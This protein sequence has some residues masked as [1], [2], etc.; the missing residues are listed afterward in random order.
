MRATILIGG[1]I[2]SFDPMRVETADLVI[3][4]DVIGDLETKIPTTSTVDC[5]GCVIMPGF[6]V[7]HTHLYS[8]LAPGMPGPQSP[9]STFREILERIWWRLDEALDEESLEISAEIASAAALRAG[10]TTVVDHHESPRFIDGALDVIAKAIGEIGIRGV[11]AYGATDRHGA[12]G[13][14]RGLAESERF[15]RKMKDD[16][17]VRGM[18]G[19]HAPFTC[20]DRTL[21]ACRD[22]IER[23]GAWLHLHAAEGPDDQRAAQERWGTPL[24]SHLDRAGLLT[25]KTLV[26][27]AVDLS[28]EE[29]RLVRARNAWVAHQARSNM[30]NGVGYA[31]KLQAIDR[32]ALGT[33]GIDQDA[34]EELRAAFF[35]RR[36]MT[37]PSSWLDPVAWLSRG[38]RLISEVFGLKFGGLEKGSPADVVVLSYDPPTP[39]DVSSIGAHMLFGMASLHVR[40]VFVGGRSVMRNRRLVGIDEKRLASRA[41]EIA[42]KLWRRMRPG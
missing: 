35:R 39:L 10:V 5:S 28:D 12:E 23:S 34:L 11:L 22:A 27:H 26:A 21:A 19:L 20:S 14:N 30:N 15:A 33:D 24:F 7:A 32:V 13:A 9:P 38:H 17:R 31:S 4:D 36:E 41:R 8:A 29:A 40:D 3:H 2:V 6:V 18:I 42:P 25:A 16:P 1:R 37:G